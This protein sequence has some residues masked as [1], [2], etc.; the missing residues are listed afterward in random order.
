MPARA[1]KVWRIGAPPSGCFRARFVE[2]FERSP[3][4]DEVAG[5]FLSATTQD[6]GEE[7]KKR[8]WAGNRPDRVVDA[9]PRRSTGWQLKTNPFLAYP[10][11][12]LSWR[13]RCN[14]DRA[15]H[16]RH[17]QHIAHTLREE[18]DARVET[19]VAAE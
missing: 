15:C 6:S 16:L 5:C 11:R 1:D 7:T 12:R 17:V 3:T 4:A 14:A 13:Y 10:Q 8:D 9:R 19:T 2:G 18:F